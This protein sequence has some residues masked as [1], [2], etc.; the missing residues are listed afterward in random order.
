[1]LS[2][3]QIY[4]NCSI[5]FIALHV[6]ALNQIINLFF[7]HSGVSLEHADIVDDVRLQV[8]QLILLLGLH[9]LHRLRLN[10]ELPLTVDLC[11][12]GCLVRRRL[13]SLLL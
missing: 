5:I 13:Q 6:F 9:D 11:D 2:S 3:G 10:H 4:E 12:L 8:H 1:M 7:D